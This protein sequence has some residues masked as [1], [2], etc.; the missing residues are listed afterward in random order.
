[1]RYKYRKTGH[2][3]KDNLGYQLEKVAK[4]INQKSY[5]TRY[6]YLAAMQRFIKFLAE[7][8]RLQKIAN[9]KD[10]HLEA[11]V[12]YQKN[13]GNADKYIKNE[14]SA[15]RFFHNINPNSKKTLQEAKKFNAAV[16]L[17]STT[18]IKDVDRSWSEKEFDEFLQKANNL[19]RPEIKNI[20]LAMRHLGLR[21]NEAVRIQHFHIVR[22]LTTGKLHIHHITKGKVPRDIILTPNAKKHFKNIIK[23]VK[24]GEHVYTPKNYVNDHKIQKFTKKIQNF[25]YDHRKNIQLAE[26]QL[27]AHNVES[28]MKSALTPH[29]LRHTFAKEKYTLYRKKG[30]SVNQA[31]I[32]VSKELG[33]FRKEITEVYLA[34]LE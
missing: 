23:D 11:Y 3:L 13:K 1:M 29:G 14:L 5:G 31:K 20:F 25:I 8:F 27:S 24:P 32:A 26:R 28:N 12:K 18:N 16:G 17:G 4:T 7:E 15:I 33:H 22:A 6:R 21:V 9:I 30:Y 34:S 10:K 2:G 19:N